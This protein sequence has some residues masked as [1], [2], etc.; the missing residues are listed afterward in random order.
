[1]TRYQFSIAT[2]SAVLSMTAG[3]AVAGDTVSADQILGALKPKP[4]T[5]GLSAG[6]LRLPAPCGATDGL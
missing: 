1:M 2:I 4:V 6:S 5:R 3:L